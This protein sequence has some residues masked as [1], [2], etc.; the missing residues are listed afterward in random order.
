MPGNTATFHGTALFFDPQE[1]AVIVRT[2]S[3]ILLESTQ[4]PLVFTLGSLT[5]TQNSLGQLVIEG[6]TLARGSTIDFHGTT[7]SL[8][9]QATAVVV[10]EIS[11]LYLQ[12]ALM[13]A[14]PLA[15]PK[16]FAFDGKAYAI[17][18]GS[19]IVI[20]GIIVT[21]LDGRDTVTG[22]QT[23][24]HNLEGNLVLVEGAMTS[25]VLGTILSPI[26]GPTPAGGFAV[27]TLASLGAATAPA[28]LQPSSSDV[29]KKG[30]GDRG[31]VRGRS[32]A[33]GVLV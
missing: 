26:P 8:N 11:K 9:P 27:M 31:R 33:I 29:R 32:L 3:T 17:P 7:L 30:H 28:G 15:P 20:D 2:T 24:S 19:S 5:F 21:L 16:T 22:G 25:T 10:D 6:Q 23:L 14:A 4:I 12:P 1:T 18:Q 13:A